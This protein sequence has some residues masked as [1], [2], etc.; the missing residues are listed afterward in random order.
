MRDKK[1]LFE[2]SVSIEEEKHLNFVIAHQQNGGWGEEIERSQNRVPS[3]VVTSQM[4]IGLLPYIGIESFNHLSKQIV[5]SIE[6]GLQYLIDTFKS[7]GWGDHSGG[8][9]IVDATG[10]A[11]T[12]IT[13]SVSNGIG[14]PNLH[15]QVD[16]A[17]KF[18]VKQQN[19]EDGGWSV[20]EEGES[21]IQY[22]YWALKALH[23]F[24]NSE[25]NAKG[26][27]I[28]KNIEHGMKW[29]RKN[30]KIKNCKG[31]SIRI[32]GEIGA[33]ATTFGIELFEDFSVPYDKQKVFDNYNKSQISHG[34]WD[35][36]TD[37]TTVGKIPRRVYVLNDIPRILECFAHLDID[38]DAS[39]FRMVL[40]TI[41]DLEVEGGGFRYKTDSPFPTGWFTAEVLKMLS[42]LRKKFYADVEKYQQRAASVS[43]AVKKQSFS[44]AVLMIGR[45]QPPHKGHYLGLRAI[46]YGDDREFLL[47]REVLSEIV[48]LDKV[49]LG[50]ARYEINRKNPYTLGEV[51]DIWRQ[52]I[53][54]DD[55]LEEKSKLIE[56]VSC[57]SRKDLTNVAG[58]IDE[59]TY[60]RES[61]IVISGNDRIIDQCKKNS[62]KHI[63]FKRQDKELSGSKVREI[64]S[65]IDFES[66]DKSRE[67][68]ES[69]KR[70]LHPAAF[71]FMMRYG[72][73]K[74]AHKIINAI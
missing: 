34:M 46:L 56:I 36:Q 18:L 48:N 25:L 31:F 68:L 72:F 66:L 37:P 4:I 69:L 1:E 74:K 73:F 3:P 22:T 29:L 42:T 70:K 12:A 51:R 26:F 65:K 71:Q 47:P 38:F 54:N 49:F 62:I 21:K 19:S 61:I 8:P 10:A 63:Q 7:Q 39:L 45:F 6:L 57:P 27:D 58:A 41:K 28:G 14:M 32:N 53:D 15:G 17:V 44:K 60:N 5:R 30:F 24:S 35:V 9:V 67:L 2:K 43:L 11:L 55:E 23:A 40:K 13:N 59:L 64:I 52:I 16:S 33:I 50:I 20:G